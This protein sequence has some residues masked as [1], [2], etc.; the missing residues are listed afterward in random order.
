MTALHW[1]Q[2]LVQALAKILDQT[3]AVQLALG[4]DW[5]YLLRHAASKSRTSTL[6]KLRLCYGDMTN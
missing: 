6:Y 5:L 1:P 2:D 3:P 4:Q